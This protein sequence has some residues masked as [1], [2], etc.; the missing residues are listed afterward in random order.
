MA[1]DRRDQKSRVSEQAMGTTLPTGA[2]L[3]Q[4]LVTNV[5]NWDPQQSTPGWLH[6]LPVTV[7]ELC[8]KWQI[9]LDS[10]IPES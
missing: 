8:A 5:S 1:A 6:S 3:P 2:R 7:E 9:T 10:V 4:H